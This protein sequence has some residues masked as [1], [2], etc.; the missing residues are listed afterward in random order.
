MFLGRAFAHNVA[1][2]HQAGGNADTRLQARLV[3]QIESAHRGNDVQAAADRA[4]GVVLMGQR[5]TKIHHQAVA[6][7]ARDM[8]LVTRHGRRS[9][10]H[11]GTNDVAEILW[12]H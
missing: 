1:D 5:I 9:A 2:H 7:V 3:R 6:H 10:G 8:A 4:F 11:E 12:V